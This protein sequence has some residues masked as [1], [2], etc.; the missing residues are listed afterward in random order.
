M[1]YGQISCFLLLCNNLDNNGETGLRLPLLWQC[2]VHD[3][4]LEW[5]SQIA[6]KW[7]YKTNFTI[8]I[9]EVS[10]TL[11]DS[12]LVDGASAYLCMILNVK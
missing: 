6:Q 8:L 3:C 4:F 10:L 7:Q 2:S 1:D 11:E 9:T 5:Q 12:G